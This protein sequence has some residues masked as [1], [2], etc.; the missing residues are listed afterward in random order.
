LEANLDPLR[1]CESRLTRDGEPAWPEAAPV[2]DLLLPVFFGPR[3]LLPAIIKL[4]NPGIPFVYFHTT[5]LQYEIN[6]EAT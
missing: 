3:F 1:E 4:P 6:T 5:R 2:L